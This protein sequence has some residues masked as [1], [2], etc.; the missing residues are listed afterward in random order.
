MDTLKLNET[1]G[2]YRK[3]Q[4]F[5]PLLF[6]FYFSPRLREQHAVLRGNQIV[7]AS[8]LTSAAISALS[9]TRLLRRFV[10]RNA[11]ALSIRNL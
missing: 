8:E 11:R 5:Y 7:I 1:I 9:S 3:K 2:F 6:S 10:S 4:G